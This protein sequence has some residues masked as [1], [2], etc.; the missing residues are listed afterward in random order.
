MQLRDLISTEYGEKA[1][2]K[3]NVVI[4]NDINILRGFLAS[5]CR[6]MNEKQVCAH[7]RFYE[8]SMLSMAY[9]DLGHDS[10]RNM[11]QQKQIPLPPRRDRDDIRRGLFINLPVQNPSSVD[12]R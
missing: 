3:P 8:S 10:S 7:S 11:D 2:N 9:G 5:F 1:T 12:S 6:N 4:L